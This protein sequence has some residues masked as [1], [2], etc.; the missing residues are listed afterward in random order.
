[1]RNLIRV[2]HTGKTLLGWDDD[3]YRFTLA[4]LTGKRS[5]RD[6]TEAELES[7]LRHM[8][9]QGFTPKHGRRP[10]VP[11]GRKAVL[12]KIEALLADAG[13]S[14]AYARGMASHMF[15]QRVIEWLDDE[16]LTK[17]MQALIIDAR[18]R[19]PD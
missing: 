3:T 19:N 13:R 14:W 18:R 5:A 1:M 2:I 4:R 9:Q 10:S 12:G 8:R 16:Q 7:V 15:G 11:R 6:C 17:L